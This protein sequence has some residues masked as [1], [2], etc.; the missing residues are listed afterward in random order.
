MWSV[1]PCQPRPI[2]CYTCGYDLRHK[3]FASEYKLHVTHN[4]PK[5]KETVFNSIDG[6]LKLSAMAGMQIS[7]IQASNLAYVVFQLK[8]LFYYK[9]WTTI[10]IFKRTGTKWRPIYMMLSPPVACYPYNHGNKSP[11]YLK[12]NKFS[13]CRPNDKWP[14]LHLKPNILPTPLS[15]LLPLQL[16]LL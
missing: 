6:I 11:K 13:G 7:T 5:A 10:L 3:P 14:T 12:C 2:Q 15:I 16:H 1:H 8:K 9:I 4:L